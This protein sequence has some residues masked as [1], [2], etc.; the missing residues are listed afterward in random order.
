MRPI[1]EG[2]WCVEAQMAI[3]G[4]P[5][6]LRMT[7]MRGPGGG[8]VLH[9]PVE[10]DDATAEAIDALG[11]VEHIVAPSRMHHLYV[12]GAA[13][14]W[15]GAKLWAAPGLP[16]KRRDLGFDD[17]IGDRAPEALA[18]TLDVALFVGA[19]VASELLC[20]HRSSRTLV[21]VDLVFNIH[22]S[23]S[24]VSRLYLRSMGGWQRLAQTPVVRAMIRDREGARRSLERVFEWDFDRLVMAH[25]EIIERGAKAQLAVALEQIAPGLPH[26]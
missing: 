17:V 3:A 9:S 8:L 25:G 4:M 7:V 15:P 11:P 6:S 23:T 22:S 2:L 16:A 18:D 19:P 1:A 13:R 10:L 12:L 5:L 21:V 14:R 20:F 24:L 26:R